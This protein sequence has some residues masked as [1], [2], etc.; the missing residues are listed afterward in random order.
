MEAWVHCLH[1]RVYVNHVNV[2]M[3]TLVS[4]NNAV[5][6]PYIEILWVGGVAVC[7]SVCKYVCTCLCT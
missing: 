3:T 6:L 7:A 4:V 5:S 1:V 2:V